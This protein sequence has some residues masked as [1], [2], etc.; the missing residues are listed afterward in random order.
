M[1]CWRG[2]Q[3][4]WDI[5]FIQWISNVQAHQ[6]MIRL[7]QSSWSIPGQIFPSIRL[8]FFR[9]NGL[10]HWI[11]FLANKVQE[12]WNLELHCCIL[13]VE[14]WQVY[15]K[16]QVTNVKNKKVTVNQKPQDLE[17]KC[18]FENANPYYGPL[19]LNIKLTVNPKPSTW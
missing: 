14:T 15:I 4:L 13:N 2:Q 5:E 10:K 9:G 1:V 16:L 8:D 6:G 7:C 3:L 17:K 11:Q 12:F 19:N 18:S